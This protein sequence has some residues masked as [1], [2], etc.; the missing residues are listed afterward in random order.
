[1]NT[2]EAA[3]NDHIVT[4]PLNYGIIKIE[5]DD[6]QGFL[7]NQFTN[8]LKQGVN[9]NHS[10]LSAYCNPKGRMLA[11]FRIFQ[12][13][14]AYFM[15]MPKAVIEATIK[16]LRMFVLMSKVTLTDVSEEMACIGFSGAESTARLQATF[17]DVPTEVDAVVSKDGVS[18]IL[19]PGIHPRYEIVGPTAAIQVLQEKLAEGCALGDDNTWTLLDIKTGMPTVQI[20]NVEAFVPQMINLQAVNGLSF[21]KGCYP[22]QEVVARMQYLGKLKRRM[23]LLETDSNTTVTTGDTIFTQNESGEE[24]KAGVVVSAQANG[25]G[26]SMLAVV[27]IAS[28]EGG[29]LHLESANGPALTIA[30]LPYTIG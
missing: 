8:D 20:E 17:G 4:T 1:M 21:K 6:A 24:H 14:G 5:G 12:Q 10:Q 29:T 26:T 18:A 23:Y 15:V 16:R 27:E 2:I 30:E 3:L 28:T 7:H 22:G 11:L 25:A 19:I 13:D 9:E